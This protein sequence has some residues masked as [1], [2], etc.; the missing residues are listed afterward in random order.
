M[1]YFYLYIFLLTF[2]IIGVSYYNTFLSSPIKK[3]GFYNSNNNNSNNKSIV[4]L[5]DSILKNNTYTSNGKGIDDLLIE[6]NNG[7]VYCYAE[8]YSKITDVYSQINNI[9]PEL[10]NQ[11]TTIFLSSGGNDLLTYYDDM[12]S[13]L[14]DMSVLNPMFSGYKK[15]VKNINTK[16]PNSKLVLLDIY[17]P[18]NIRFKPYHPIISQWNSKLY[19][20]ANR[21]QN[22][23]LRVSSM[24][25][26]SDDFSFGIEPS[27]IGG[28]KIAN[29][30]LNYY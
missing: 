4:L 20:Y 3:E 16:F 14:D 19:N 23:V 18:Y 1:K 21:Q 30:I 24:L 11:N 29:S 26:N 15:V 17:Y 12:G 2:F 5:G 7:G 28:E 10:N 6:R 8:D 22:N 27:S 25:T 9:P 13:N